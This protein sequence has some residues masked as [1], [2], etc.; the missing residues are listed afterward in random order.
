MTDYLTP[1]ADAINRFT[2]T[3]EEIVS[4]IE[5]C[6]PVFFMI[7]KK[8]IANNRTHYIFDY[9]DLISNL[10]L[11]LLKFV[12]K[13]PKDVTAGLIYTVLYRGLVSNLR[14]EHFDPRSDKP[15]FLNVIDEKENPVSYAYE[16]ST[17]K[18]IRSEN[19]EE[20][21]YRIRNLQLD[22]RRKDIL[23]YLILQRYSFADIARLF[24]VSESSISQLFQQGFRA[25]QEQYET[26]CVKYYWS[27]SLSVRHI[28][29]LLAF[30]N[31][32]IFR[33]YS[34]GVPVKRIVTKYKIS[35]SSVYNVLL[36]KK[37]PFRQNTYMG[38]QRVK[39]ER[40]R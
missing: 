23:E 2:G 25:L 17:M 1:A 10:S 38:Q 24:K 27:S 29:N 19:F 39:Q 13:N 35:E 34:N 8:F 26:T 11:V 14:A 28:D 36:Q 30:R 33:D 21:A 16:D 22:S 7:A 12:K 9:D 20:I 15:V 4:I 5:M 37:D 3:N 18:I 40:N 32:A 31:D 6:R